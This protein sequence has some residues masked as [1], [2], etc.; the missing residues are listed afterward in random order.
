MVKLNSLPQNSWRTN[1][2]KSARRSIAP[3]L[4]GTFMLRVNGGAG[5]IVLG[6][7]LA[8]LSVQS[9]HAISSIHVGLIAVAYYIVELTLAPI[10][11]AVSDRLGRRVF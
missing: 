11:G 9:G 4:L 5:S 7:F 10:L 6:R 3:L 2:A 8:Q 1:G